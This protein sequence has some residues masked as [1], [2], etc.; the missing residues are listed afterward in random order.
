[1]SRL[2]MHIAE[3]ALRVRDLPR[4]KAFYQERLGL[5]VE[6]EG[7]HHVFLKVGE[8]PSPLG[9]VGHPQ[10]LVLF[11]RQVALD[12]ATTTLDHLAFEIPPDRLATERQ[13][14]R[15]RGELVRE[16]AWPETLPWRARAL[17][18]YDPEGNVVE[19]IARDPDVAL[20]AKAQADLAAPDPTRPDPTRPDPGR[21]DLTPPDQP[22]LETQE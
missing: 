21:P 9:Q 16:R 22:G 5:E 11:D 17:F 3:V 20:P 10:M 13:R 19:L 4:M 15:A 6:L 18:F 14:L 2:I 12:Q 8:L 1:M 7:D